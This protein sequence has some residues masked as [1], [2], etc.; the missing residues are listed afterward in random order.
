MGAPETRLAP[1]DHIGRD[2]ALPVGRP[3]QRDQAPFAGHEILDFDG[4]A[5]GEDIRIA[6]AHLFVYA[7]PPAFADLQSGHFRQRGIR[8]HADGEDHHVSRIGLSGFGFHIDGA[9]RRLF[10]PGHPVAVRQADTMPLQVG[11]NDAGMFRIDRGQDLIEHLHKGDFKAAMD[12]VFRHL[13]ADEPA[14]DNHGPGLGSSGLESRIPVHAGEKGVA[15]FNPL[16]DCPGVRHRPHVKNARKVYSRQRRVDGS[17][18]GRQHQLVVCSVVTSPVA[19]FSQLHGFLLRRDLDRLATGCAHQWRTGRG[20]DCSFA[21]SRLD[22]F[23]I[24]PPT[25]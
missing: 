23:S 4:V 20:T 7:D 11:L 22:S 2:P 15:A 18:P 5:D 9:V 12:Q 10:E 1:G 25:W 24:T 19:R 13:Q 8:P 17:G 6:R 14:T 3:G 16:T 21:T